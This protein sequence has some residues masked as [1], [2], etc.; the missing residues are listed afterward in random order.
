M[1]PILDPVLHQQLRL[2]VM[3]LLLAR[4]QADFSYLMNETGATKGNLSVQLRK[5]EDAGYLEITKKGAGPASRTTCTITEVGIDAFEAY[6]NAIDAYV[7]QARN[8]GG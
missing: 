7:N 1:L 5:L 2:A 6:V 3:S 4:Q 8:S